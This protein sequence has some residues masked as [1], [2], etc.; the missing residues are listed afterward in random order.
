M[1][2]GSA[3][4]I[5]AAAPWNYKIAVFRSFIRRAVLVCSEDFLDSELNYIVN[6]DLR[7]G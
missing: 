3:I 1:K 7:H 5:T 2:L 6:I 4:P